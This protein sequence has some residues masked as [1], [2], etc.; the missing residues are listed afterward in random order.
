[1]ASLNRG[2]QAIAVGVAWIAF[3]PFILVTLVLVG[4]PALIGTAVL[5]EMG[6]QWAKDWMQGGRVNND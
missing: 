3:S 4:F 5:S 6:V 2:L 1:M